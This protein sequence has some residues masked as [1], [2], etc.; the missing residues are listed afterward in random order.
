MAANG[1]LFWDFDGTLAH[2]PGMWRG[3]LSETLA[4]RYPDVAVTAE[5]LRPYVNVGFPWHTPEVPHPELCTSELWWEKIEGVLAR[6]YRAVGLSKEVAAALACRAH[7]RY[8]DPAS[9]V[10]YDDVLPTLRH[11]AQHGWRHI[12]VSNHVPELPALVGE[13][14]LAP[15]VEHVITSAATGYEKP[16]AEMYR[17]ALEA[18]GR[19]TACWMAGDNVACDVLGP[20]KAGIRGIL[21]RSKDDRATRSCLD[22]RGVIGYVEAST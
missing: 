2:R 1:V 10:V 21:V 9:W 5:E 6:A 17:L 7:Q 20:E 8:L 18:A 14:G 12:V 3:L 19:P 11:L 4:E 16:H 13:I 22:L 15:L